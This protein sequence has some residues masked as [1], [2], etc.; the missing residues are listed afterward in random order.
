MIVR[1][2]S[3]FESGMWMWWKYSEGEYKEQS[4]VVLN[5]SMT[6]S[7]HLLIK[8]VREQIIDLVFFLQGFQSGNEILFL[9]RLCK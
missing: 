2:V 1:G 7:A 6:Q 5:F 4:A 9:E 3:K 8:L